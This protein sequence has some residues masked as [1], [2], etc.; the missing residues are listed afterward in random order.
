M[1]RN[2]ISKDRRTRILLL[3]AQ[4][5]ALAALVLGLI[6]LVNTTGG[7]LFLFSA[8][9]PVLVGL[10]SPW[11]PPR[12]SAI[13]AA[14]TACSRLK[15]TNRTTSCSGKA[16]LASA[17]TSSIRARWKSS[18]QLPLEGGEGREEGLVHPGKSSSSPP[19]TLKDAK[20]ADLTMI[21]AS[22]YGCRPVLVDRPAPFRVV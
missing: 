16:I 20:G 19:N 18:D 7:T 2:L 21:P 22:A 8:L 14:S 3:T 6:F 12:P 17:P 9:A 1:A 11:W 13:T 10:V 4:G 15:N 5:L